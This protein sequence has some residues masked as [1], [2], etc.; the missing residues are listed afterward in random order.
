VRVTFEIYKPSA[1]VDLA[2]VAGAKEYR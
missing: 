2:A 1:T